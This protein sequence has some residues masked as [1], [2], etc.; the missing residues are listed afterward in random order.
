LVKLSAHL[1]DFLFQNTKTQ[2]M[3]LNVNVTLFTPA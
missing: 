3:N 1:L 2:G